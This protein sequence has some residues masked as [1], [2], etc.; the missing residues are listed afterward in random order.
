MIGPRAKL[1][2]QL[3]NFR[4]GLT[5]FS[6][7]RRTTSLRQTLTGNLRFYRTS[8]VWAKRKTGQSDGRIH[9]ER[10]MAGGEGAWLQR[11]GYAATAGIGGKKPT[12]ITSCDD[13]GPSIGA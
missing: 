8:R 13:V 9:T 7:V 5:L 1:G 2:Y 12:G 10:H 4:V 6:V 11:F 3:V